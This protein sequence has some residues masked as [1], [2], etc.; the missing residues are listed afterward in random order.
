M[1][2]TKPDTATLII[3]L[4]LLWLMLI[5]SPFYAEQSARLNAEDGMVKLYYPLEHSSFAGQV[6]LVPADVLSPEGQLLSALL[7]PLNVE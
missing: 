1:T 4:I 6:Y 7:A 3:A 2:H 5:P